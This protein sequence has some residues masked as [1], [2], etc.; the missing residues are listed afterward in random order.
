MVF[1]SIKPIVGLQEWAWCHYGAVVPLRGLLSSSR[2]ISCRINRCVEPIR[3]VA[4]HI[5]RNMGVAVECLRYRGV[6]QTFLDDLRMNAFRQQHRGA[7]VAKIVEA[8]GRHLCADRQLP[9]PT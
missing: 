1:G 3:S 6:T 7:R 2:S 4:L 5:F 9:K 8:N